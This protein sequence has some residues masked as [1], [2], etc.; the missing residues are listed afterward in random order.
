MAKILIIDD[1]LMVRAIVVRLLEGGRARDRDR[2]GRPQ[3]LV[4]AAYL[5]DPNDPQWKDDPAFKDWLAFMQ[6]Y[7]PEGNLGDRF[8]VS[9]CARPDGGAGAETVRRRPLAREDHAPAGQ[10]RS[11]AFHAAAG[12]QGA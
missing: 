4:S 7:D 1:D 8:D 9:G 5:K 11:R 12:H 2:R 3:G 6:R 10:P